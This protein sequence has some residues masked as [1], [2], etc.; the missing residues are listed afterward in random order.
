MFEQQ[1][2]EAILQRCLARVSHQV[3]KREG[4]ILY[5]ALA[6]A[7]VELAGFYIALSAVLDRAFPDTAVGEDL[8]RKCAER[9]IHRQPATKAV[10]RA[11]F[12]GATVAV[13]TRFSGGSVNYAVTVSDGGYQVTAEQ[14]GELG[15]AYFGA[16]IPIDYVAGLTVA[17]LEETL[18]A[19]EDAE[20]DDALRKRYFDSFDNQAFGG[21]VAY[22]KERVGAL[23]G[24]GGVKVVRGASGG[25]TVGL[26]IVGSDWTVPSTELVQSVQ[27]A[28]DPIV[29]HGAGVGFAPIGHTVTVAGVTGQTV[30]V[31][32]TLTL[33]RNV[34][35]Q[36]TQILVRQTIE[37]YL[38]EL[39][40][41]WADAPHLVVRISQIETRI[42]S[43]SG[44]LDIEATTLNGQTSNLVLTAMQIPILGGVVD[45][46]V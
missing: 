1:T 15:N 24:V 38:K 17:T 37:D 45:G 7:C 46:I 25:G 23:D 43:I 39:I 18:V 36:S 8:E 14:A 27:T 41:T 19:G 10:R 2:Y 26:T 28:V 42:L 3:D 4:S 44:V 40:Q 6:P 12:A 34:T 21:N 13:G 20:E 9:S 16:L 11:V 35:W 22:Y 33:E 5:D 32:F 30:D 29:N 31:A